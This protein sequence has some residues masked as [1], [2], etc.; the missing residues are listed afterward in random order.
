M[1][2]HNKYQ[3]T[4]YTSFTICSHTHTHLHNA[5][6]KASGTQIEQ[7]TQSNCLIGPHQPTSGVGQQKV[8]L[9]CCRYPGLPTKTLLQILC[10]QFAID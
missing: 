3:F 6:H 4:V 5:I 2:L 10:L 1:Y 8:R 9:L 7:T